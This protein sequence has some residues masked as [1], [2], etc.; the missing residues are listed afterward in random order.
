MKRTIA[1]VLSVLLVLAA[2]PSAIFAAQTI[3]SGNTITA[4]ANKTTFETTGSV[5]SVTVS[6]DLTETVT[7]SAIEAY[8]P[9]PDGWSITEIV[10]EDI[11]YTNNQSSQYSNAIY[12][13]PDL[14]IDGKKCGC[15]VWTFTTEPLPAKNICKV[16]YSIPADVTEGSYELKA[17][18]R[19]SGKGIE[20]SD[21]SGEI[22]ENQAQPSVTITVVKTAVP[23]TGVELDKETA[24][25]NKDDSTTL[26]ATI[27]PAEA[28][29]KNVEWSVSPTGIVSVTPDT[30]DPL[31]A[32]VTGLAPGQ[33][34]VTVTTADGNKTDS[35]VID[36]YGKATAPTPAT[37]LEYNGT[38][39]TGVSVP[40]NAG[41]SVK[42][43]D[44]SATDA[45]NY[46]AV[47]TLDDHYKWSDEPFTGDRTVNWSIAK[48]TI[49]VP[50]ANTG[51]VYDGTEKTGV[52]DPAANA[53][54]TVTGNK[55]TNAGDYKA[56]VTPDANHRFSDDVASKE[57]SW[58]IAKAT[59]EVPTANTGLVYDGTEKTGVDDPAANA[60]YTVTGNKQ[61]NAGDYEA[62][63]T[64]D[65]NHRFSDDASSKT[66]AWSI[67]R[68]GIDVPT[69]NSPAPVYD[70]TQKT[71]VDAGNYYT[72]TD[73]TGT[74]AGNYT[75]KATPDSNHKWNGE[76]GDAATATKEIPWAIARQQVAVPAAE[77]GLVYDGTTKTG[78]PAGDKYDIS[79][80]TGT[81]AKNDYE[82]TASLK[83]KNNYEWAT[84]P[85]TTDDQK[86]TWAIAQAELKEDSME[87]TVGGTGTV[88]GGTGV[89]Y[90]V[91]PE[92]VV[93][94]DNNGN[95]TGVAEGEATI[96]V[97]S[98]GTGNYERGQVTI[99]VNVV[100]PAPTPTGDTTMR[101]V[102]I[103]TLA[104][105]VMAAFIFLPKRK[106]NEE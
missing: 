45:G 16:T 86:I 101:W 51:L 88:P 98:D 63:V 28:D 80:N 83:D 87:I 81:D 46:S 13:V 24:E 85:A 11:T 42:S 93:E 90:E 35:A 104:L 69:A 40:A 72:I 5:Q 10:G 54:Y 95:V 49:A 38:T 44:V 105:V 15:L 91:T 21:G 102:A 31:K 75:A 82:A 32:T 97:S 41:Y 52:D 62:T 84:S 23:V 65:S 1:I 27:S 9:F 76:T 66:V 103:G 70:G 56:T 55:Q 17:T 8:F 77:T 53:G 94:I 39:Q 58:S 30:D 25:I 92:G 61:T 73:N 19:N 43:G 34:T 64:P 12:E 3:D 47:L 100:Q 59:I 26:T 79:G 71:G 106:E 50:T 14:T 67:A 18:N 78:V 6:Y 36:V 48:A 2:I 4:T 37:N 57:V 60:G 33:A 68:A 29:N 89:G 74:N 96:Y 99:T 20:L 22:Y 7:L